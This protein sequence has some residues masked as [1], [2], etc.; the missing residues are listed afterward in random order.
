MQQDTTAQG[1][2]PVT[3]WSRQNEKGGWD[4]NH[5]EMGHVPEG[6]ARPTPVHESHK[7]A[8]RKGAWQAE[9]AYLTADKPPR[10]V[11]Q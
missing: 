1:V 7:S 9:R 6:T 4:H 5:L 2:T 10:V 11:R 8:W 3:L